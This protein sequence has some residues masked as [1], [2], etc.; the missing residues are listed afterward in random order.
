MTALPVMFSVFMFTCSV[1][2]AAWQFSW[3]TRTDRDGKPAGI[4]ETTPYKIDENSTSYSITNDDG[5]VTYQLG[6]KYY[7]D[8]GY[9]G[10]SSDGSWSKPWTTIEDALDNVAEGNKTIIIRGAHDGFDGYYP[11]YDLSLKSGIDDTHRFMLVGYGQ[12]RPIINGESYPLG[13]DAIR[14]SY[15]VSY[16]TVQRV[17]IQD[18]IKAGIRTGPDDSYINVIDVWLYNN[19]K[20]DWD[21]FNTDGDGTHADGNLYF[22]G[23]DNCFIRHCLSEHTYGHAFKIGDGADNPTVEWAV[24]REFGYWEGF[25]VPDYY[26]SHPSGIDFPCDNDTYVE[27][28]I[29]VRYCIVHTGQFYGMQLRTYGHGNHEIKFTEIWDTTHFDDVNGAAS[30]AITPNQVALFTCGDV[31]FHDNIVRDSGDTYAR[32]IYCSRVDGTAKIYNNLFYNNYCSIYIRNGDTTS[33]EL[34]GN[35]FYDNNSYSIVDGYISER[36]TM[37]NNIFYQA[38]SGKCANISSTSVKSDNHYYSPAGSIGI[39]LG[40]NDTDG[41]PNWK[42]LPSGTYNSSMFRLSESKPGAN[43]STVFTRDFAG[44]ARSTWDKGAFEFGD[45]GEPTPTSV[46]GEATPTPK[47]TQSPIPTLANFRTQ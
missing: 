22:L 7:V 3:D 9:T 27:K 37:K 31:A 23:S 25:D 42:A 15:A 10:G 28:N 16:A 35:S 43:L 30:H 19:D 26:G 38:G 41:N 11:E 12:E 39:S 20:F 44:S 5:T 40:T 6:T 13:G 46:P 45:D 47:P 36:L 21:A 18:C 14:A 8:G 32:G 29:M 1:S 17:K 24:A 2:F 4:Y 34:Y 33:I